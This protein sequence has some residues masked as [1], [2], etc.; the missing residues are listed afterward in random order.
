MSKYEISG[1]QQL[2]AVLQKVHN[3]VWI[4]IKHIENAISSCYY[5]YAYTDTN[6]DLAM[7]FYKVSSTAA[8]Y[9]ANYAYIALL[10]FKTIQKYR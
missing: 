3:D 10:S 4:I 8:V 9:A 5:V 1:L 7:F 6:F 2:F